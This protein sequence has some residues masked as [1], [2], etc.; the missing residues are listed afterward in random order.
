MSK[1]PD[2][3][4]HTP[5]NYVSPLSAGVF[6]EFASAHT[7]LFYHPA[8]ASNAYYKQTVSF[9]GV[10]IFENTFFRTFSGPTGE[11]IG[12]STILKSGIYVVYYEFGFSSPSLDSGGQRL[13]AEFAVEYTFIVVENRLPLKKWTVTEV[14]NRLC[15][16]AKPIR[17]GEKPRFRLQ[18]VVGENGKYTYEA[19]SQ[20]EKFDKIPAPEFSFTKQTLRECLKQVGQ[21]VHGE[22]RLTPKKDGAGEWYYEV[23]YDLYGGTRQWMHANRR[24]IANTV[25]NTIEQYATELDSNP[26]N[27]ISKLKDYD[28]VTVE[29]YAG[30]ARSVRTEQTYVQITE[31]NMLIATQ[32]PIYTVEKLEY[33]YNTEDEEGNTVEA[34]ADI[35]A[36]L[37]ESSVYS[38]QL[39]SYD[40]QY[41][42]S[43][44]YGLMYT[45]GEKNI[46]AL[47]FKQEHPISPIFEHYAIVNIIREVTGDRNF[48]PKSENNDYA[49]LCFRVTYTPFYNARVKQT[50]TNYT[51]YEIP[52]TRIYNQFSNL[53]ESRSFGEN[54]KGVIARM[55]NP[56]ISRTYMFSRL[57][58]IPRAGMK[59][60]EDYYISAV[61]SEILPTY[62]RSTVA[63]TRDFN[64]ISQFIGIPSVKR[65]SQVSDKMAFDRNIVYEEYIVIGDSET[66]DEDCM[67]GV[68][69]LNGLW[70]AFT[71][72]MNGY[73]DAFPVSCV[74]AWGESYSLNGSIPAVCLPVVTSAYGNSIVFSWEY[75]DNYSAGTSSEYRTNGKAGNDAVSGYFQQDLPYADYYGRM[76]YYNFDLRSGKEF[77]GDPFRLPGLL[78]E[79]DK[80]VSSGGYFSTVGKAPFILRKDSREKLQ[81]NV[82]IYL[83]TNRKGLIIGSALASYCAAV[84]SVDSELKASLYILKEPIDKFTDRLS[85]SG[86]SLSRIL[87]E[88]PSRVMEISIRSTQY[89]LGL[90]MRRMEF[91]ADG[92]AWVIA[93]K[94]TECP[95]ENVMDEEGD[96]SEQRRIKGGDLL[97]AQN[98][99]I[100]AG[101]TFAPIFFTAKRNVYKGV[102]WKDKL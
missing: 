41:P 32:R 81:V 25:A 30:G 16:L 83:V 5:A 84:R 9:N 14:I 71:Q 92:E 62:I 49:K 40:S 3:L 82:Q 72:E 24:Y 95:P 53:V 56:E 35:T 31:S 36:Y 45:Q 57:A 7:V 55:G 96:E 18:G 37:F 13:S 12:Y 85:S 86:I 63:L 90:E 61:F 33:I 64:R 74:V 54:L 102:V 23:S 93:T 19:G 39:S 10:N 20:A 22:P 59:F 34:A 88:D 58:Q 29:P 87:E 21:I 77:G 91:T 27:L 98:M 70:S 79:D 89:G 68:R 52:A 78:N 4:P 101:D 28:G 69:I 43:K 67:M 75:Q 26:E 94:E 51:E 44:A 48:S 42:Y 6:F 17:R 1:I 47:N 15:D 97:L 80:P 11:D 76:Y 8:A 50:K 65:Y 38:S 99:K 66:A 73:M 2:F 60:N 100:S 46:T